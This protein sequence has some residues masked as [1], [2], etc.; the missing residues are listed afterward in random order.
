[1]TIDVADTTGAPLRTMIER[2]TQGR[3]DHEGRPPA[4]IADERGPAEI[5][6]RSTS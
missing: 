4:R 3:F 5:D 1:M 6:E 2:W